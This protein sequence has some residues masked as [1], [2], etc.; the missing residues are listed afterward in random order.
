MVKFPVSFQ[1]DTPKVALSKFLEKLK[2]EVWRAAIYGKDG[3]VRDVFVRLHSTS[4]SPGDLE[5]GENPPAPTKF[6]ELIEEVADEE[7]FSWDRGSSKW[8]Q[9]IEVQIEEAI[10]KLANLCHILSEKEEEAIRK[11]SGYRM[12]VTGMN[13]ILSIAVIRNQKD[14][15]SYLLE[16]SKIDLHTTFGLNK[17]T[18]LHYAISFKYWD[19]AKMIL[20]SSSMPSILYINTGNWVQNTAL[21]ELVLGC[22]RK[23]D[24]DPNWTFDN[25]NEHTILEMLLECGANVDAI[26]FTCTTPLHRLVSRYVDTRVKSLLQ[27]LLDAGAEVNTKDRSEN[28][29]LHSACEMQDKETIQKLLDFGADMN[30][31]NNEWKTPREVFQSVPTHD[32][33]FADRKLSRLQRSIPHQKKDIARAKRSGPMSK[34][35]SRVCKNFP[36]YL[37]YRGSQFLPDVAGRRSMSWTAKDMKVFD[38]LYTPES[39]HPPSFLNRVETRFVEDVWNELSIERTQK[40]QQAILSQPTDETRRNE[41]ENAP[42]QNESGSPEKGWITKEQLQKKIAEDCYRWMNFPASNMSWIK[43]F[44]IQNTEVENHEQTLQ[45]FLDSIKVRESS[46]LGPLLRTPHT[47]AE[48]GMVSVVI[49]FLDFETSGSM[50]IARRKIQKLEQA[51][52]PFTGVDGLQVP[53]TIDETS[54]KTGRLKTLGTK[55]NQVIYRWSQ[56]PW[57]ATMNQEPERYIYDRKQHFANLLTKFLSRLWPRME[58]KYRLAAEQKMAQRRE[59]SQSIQTGLPVQTR[60]EKNIPNASRMQNIRKSINLKWLVVRQ[61]WLYKLDDKT[62]LTAIP[63]REGSNGADDLLETI[64]QKNSDKVETADELMKRIIMEAVN[65]PEEFRWAGLGEHILDIFQ[66]EITL[67]ANEELRFFNDFTN[68]DWKP[69]NVYKAIQE[70]AKSTWQLKDIRDELGLIRQVFETQKKVVKEFVNILDKNSWRYGDDL[71]DLVIVEEMIRRTWDMDKEASSIL[72]GLSSITQAMQAQASLKEAETAR[73]M[74]LIILPFTVVTVV[75]TPL[76]FMTSLFAVNSDGF[77]H[78][79]DGEL[80]LPWSWLTWR[81]FVGE[82]GTLVPLLILIMS[83][84]YYQGGKRYGKQQE[85]LSYLEK[86]I[87]DRRI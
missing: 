78:N 81:L 23:A 68:A 9:A 10:T 3:K 22:I 45:F 38:V 84:Y 33:E 17:Q 61:L 73:L 86:I 42:K 20:K 34:E 53:Q 12:S 43:D 27:Y 14:N 48:E 40:D 31:Q 7:F 67:E 62:I 37:S 72:E 6:E 51:Y 24:V 25:S 59:K 69:E 87:A 19:L 26:D 80:R 85:N 79:E 4:N 2:K 83:I 56:R 35:R 74:N 16:T 18:A 30:C 77:P 60:N 46:N 82:V 39:D 41:T 36:I 15:V 65:F 47:K 66:G 1:E 55:E 57:L 70:A 44:I 28:T 49:P 71:D 64:R 75:F 21:H 52:F 54:N 8:Q 76:S 29:P 5:A 11:N 13:S 58:E 32:Q 63:L 50:S